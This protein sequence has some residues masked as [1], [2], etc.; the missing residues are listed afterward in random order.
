MEDMREMKVIP[1]VGNEKKKTNESN[2]NSFGNFSCRFMYNVG[3]P[4]NIVIA[5]AAYAV[6]M[7]LPTIAAV[8]FDSDDAIGYGVIAYTALYMTIYG[9]CMSK[10]TYA[11]ETEEAKD[12]D[13]EEGKPTTKTLLLN[14]TK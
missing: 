5:V 12:H 8:V 14:G 9:A 3:K 6:G 4:N 2:P 7:L 13:I 11:K 10:H 1:E